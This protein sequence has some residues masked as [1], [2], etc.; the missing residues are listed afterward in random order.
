MEIVRI[1]E[2]ED[3][4]LAAFYEGEEDDEFSRLFEE[5]TDIEKL[6][7]FFSENEEDLQRHHWGNIT[8]EEAIFA[9]RKEAITLRKRFREISE[10]P[11]KE[12]VESFIKLFKPLDLRLRNN[13]SFERKKVYGTIRRSFLR[14]YALRIGTEMYLITGGAIKLTDTMQERKHTRKELDKLERCKQYFKDLGIIDEDGV[15]DLLEI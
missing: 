6:E 13:D 3:C 12:R 9:V 2:D 14:M 4:L 7:K 10:E 1:Y 11:S 5:W 8:I 15:I